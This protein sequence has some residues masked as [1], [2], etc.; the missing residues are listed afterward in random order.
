MLLL[1]RNALLPSIELM[2]DPRLETP[3]PA[4][5]PHRLNEGH[6]AD[7]LREPS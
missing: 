3:A 5:E 1:R 4:C 2:V 7:G 6:N